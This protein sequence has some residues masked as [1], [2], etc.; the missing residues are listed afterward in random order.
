MKSRDVAIGFHAAERRSLTLFVLAHCNCPV[1][2]ELSCEIH[3]FVRVTTPGEILR[4][5][6]S[7]SPQAG[8]NRGVHDY[9]HDPVCH[10]LR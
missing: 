1:L 4:A 5:F 9:R 8:D 2:T 7:L 3:Q 10:F 6:E